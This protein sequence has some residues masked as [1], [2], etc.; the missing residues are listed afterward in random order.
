M[1]TLS[2]TLPGMGPVRHCASVRLEFLPVA[3][4]LDSWAGIAALLACLSIG[5][6]PGLGPVLRELRF[7][8][9][10]RKA[11]VWGRNQSIL[12][13]T[14]LDV[15]E[16]DSIVIRFP[17]MRVWVLDAGGLRQAQSTEDSA[18][19]FDIGEAV[20]SRY[21]WHFWVRRIDRVMLSHPDIDHAGGTPA[22]MKNFAFNR[23]DYA[24][25]GPD[26]IIKGLLDIARERKALHATA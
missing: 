26:E 21:L 5:S 6:V 8:A 22:V 4:I 10:D 17:D 14:F 1:A 11:D 19:A 7:A 13:L 23:F 9:R 16:G 15:G 3:Q 18:Y 25:T 2:H 12:S 20:V 24:R